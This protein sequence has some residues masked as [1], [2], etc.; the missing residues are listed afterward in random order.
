MSAGN[1][2]LVVLLYIYMFSE[3]ASLIFEPKLE[4]MREHTFQIF[5]GEVFQT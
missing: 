1:R 2:S 3:S 5:E 4:G